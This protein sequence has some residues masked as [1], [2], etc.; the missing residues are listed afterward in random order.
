[1]YHFLLKRPLSYLL[2]FQIFTKSVFSNYHFVFAI[3]RV[4][5]IVEGCGKDHWGQRQKLGVVPP[6]QRPRICIDREDLRVKGKNPK[7]PPTKFNFRF[8]PRCM[9]CRR[10]LAMRILSVCPSVC[11]S[12]CP[13]HAWSLTKWKKDRSRFLYYTKEHFSEKKNG[14]WG[15]TPSTWNFGSSGPRWR[16]I[17]DFQPIIARSASAVT[18]SEKSSINALFNEPKMIVV[19]CP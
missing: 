2:V 13:S 16:K 4:I 11:L 1:M 3:C 8:L 6:L 17:A 9:K 19:R 15:T 10:G 5:A 14:W 12:V 18:P 7:W